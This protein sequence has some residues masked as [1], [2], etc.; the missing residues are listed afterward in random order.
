MTSPLLRPDVQAFIKKKDA[1]S[2]HTLVL[3]GS[4]FPE[5][6]IQDIAQQVQGRSKVKLKI[7]EWY[8]TD[9]LL[10]PPKLNLEQT[11]SEITALY[12]TSLIGSGHLLDATGGLGVDSY[13]FSK[14]VTKVTHVEFNEDLSAIAAH[15]FEILKATNIDTICEDAITYLN[16]SNDHYETIYIDPARRSDTKGKVFFLEDC[17]PDI[18]THL[19][20]LLSKCDHLW[21]KTAPMLDIS[22]GLRSLRNVAEVHVIAVK[23]EVKELLWHLTATET[24][25]DVQIQAINL[26][27]PHSPQRFDMEEMRQSQATY[28]LPQEYLYEPNAALLKAGAFQWISAAFSLDKLQEHT[29]LYTGNEYQEFPGRCFK[30]IKIRPYSKKLKK[31]LTIKKAHITTRNFRQSVATLRKELKISDG[32]NVYL[33]FT[34]QMDEKAVV[35]VCEKI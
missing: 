8:T 6:S 26:S 30:I 5:I 16:N 15:N 32:G 27:T 7:P 10:Y 3:K 14:K 9:N 4:P 29:H 25:K 13:Y 11:S 19:D 33:F 28:G 22:S 12:K 18:T 31:E 17:T 35:L 2:L 1:S 34:T 20:L 24:N 23:N 21:I